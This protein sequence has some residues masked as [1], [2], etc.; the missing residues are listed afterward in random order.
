MLEKTLFHVNLC[1]VEEEEPG[2]YFGRARVLFWK[3]QALILEELGSY[4][5]RARRLFRK[6][7]EVWMGLRGGLGGNVGWF[8]GKCGALGWFWSGF[9]GVMMFIFMYKYA[10]KGFFMLILGQKC[11][12]WVL[13]RI[14]E[15]T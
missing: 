8:W 13:A 1:S 5:G 10:A 2:A 6:G 9:W 12:F 14:R 15:N 4:F 11:E 7:V 3:S